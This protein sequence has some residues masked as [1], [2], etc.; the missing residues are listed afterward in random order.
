MPIT[1]DQSRQSTLGDLAVQRLGYCSMKLTPLGPMAPPVD[2]DTALAVLRRSVELGITHLD[3]SEL[4]GPHLANELIHEALH[5]YPEDLVIATRVG[6]RR[7]ADGAWDEALSPGALRQEVQDNLDHLGLDVADVV[8]LRMPGVGEPAER[9]V[10]EPFEALAQ[11]QREG[12][13]RHLGVSHVTP[14]QVAEARDIAPLAVVQNH[15]NLMHR[16]D[17]ALVETLARDGIAYTAL[18]G[19]SYTTFFPHGGMAPQQASVLEAVAQRSGAGPAQV[20]IAWLLARSPNVLVAPGACSVAQLEELV[21]ATALVLDPGD[22]EDLDRIAG[23]AD[24]P[25][26]S[27]ARPG[28]APTPGRRPAVDPR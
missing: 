3:T 21:G 22:L 8:Y 18:E 16:T 17:D 9:S 6:G 1:A 25:G 12:L 27:G 10:A 20:A 4:F 11:M 5:P 13:V 14:R 19:M 2:R 7:T 26:R 24:R 15:Y 28:A 23:M